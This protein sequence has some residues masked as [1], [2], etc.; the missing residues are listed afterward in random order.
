ME[1]VTPTGI[2]KCTFQD[3][4]KYQVMLVGLWCHGV[5]EGPDETVLTICLIFQLYPLAFL[6][7]IEQVM[8]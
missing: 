2:T 6:Q 4:Y 3:I 1:V 7:P 5:I 8:L